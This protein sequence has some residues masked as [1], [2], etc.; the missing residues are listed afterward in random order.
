MNMKKVFLTSFLI[1]AVFAQLINVNAAD[2]EDIS[3]KIEL[4]GSFIPAV[5]V[6]D[7][8]GNETETTVNSRTWSIDIKQTDKKIYA[9]IANKLG[10]FVY[11]VT[12]IDE[13]IK[14]QHVPELAGQ[15]L[16]TVSGNKLY[17]AYADELLYCF[18]I[19]D[20][21]TVSIEKDN[22]GKITNPSYGGNIDMMI[23]I[24]NYVFA[25]RNYLEILVFDSSGENPA[26]A[27]NSIGERAKYKRQMAVKQVSGT[28]YRISYIQQSGSDFE[29]ICTDYNS[30]DNAS[31]EVVHEVIPEWTENRFGKMAFVTDSKIAV[32]NKL[33]NTREMLYTVDF[34]D[35][36]NNEIADEYKK[37]VCGVFG[38]S[39]NTAVYA[40][41]MQ[42][43]NE[44]ELA[45]WNKASFVK[46]FASG[47]QINLGSS[48]VLEAVTDAKDFAVFGDTASEFTD[49]LACDG[50]VIAVKI[51]RKIKQKQEVE[52]PVII[53]NSWRGLPGDAIGI[54]GYGFENEAHTARVVIVPENSADEE[55]YLDIL[56]SNNTCI[57]GVIPAGIPADN[58]I[59]HVECGD[60]K[61]DSF[62]INTPS[63]DWISEP[64]FCSGQ[65]VRIFGRNFLNAQTGDISKT[66][67]WLK[68]IS[69]GSE[70]EAE[71]V[72]ATDYT[73]DFKIPEC[74][75]EGELYTVKASN[76][77]ESSCNIYE[78]EESEA[79]VCKTNI[80]F[81][82]VKEKFG[83]SIGW[84]DELVTDRIFNVKNYGAAGNGITDD[85]AAAAAALKAAKDAGG[86]IIY[87][88]E[89]KYNLKSQ[90][91]QTIPD[92]SVICGAGKDKTTL[93][94]E[95]R[96]YS[97]DNYSG[98]YDLS[99]VSESVRPEDDTAKYIF[100]YVGALLYGNGANVHFFVSNIDMKVAD[101]SSFTSYDSKHLV[102]ENSSF[103]VTHC[104]PMQQCN[105]ITKIRKMRFVNNYVKNTQRPLLY[106]GGYSWI[107]GCIFEG[108]NGG[109]SCEKTNGI[110]QTMEH[111]IADLYGDKIFY[112]NNNI[113][114][115]VG[116][117]REEYDDS[118]GEG[119]CNQANK[120]IAVGS[121]TCST[122]NTLTTELD[123]ETIKT[124]KDSNG[125]VI[126][127]YLIGS[128]VAIISGN[129]VGQVRKI[130]AVE[131]NTITVDKPWTLLPQED[132]IYALNGEIAEKYIIVNNNIE[133]VTRKGGIMMYTS[134]FDNIIE[135][136]TMTN[137]G[138]IWF[139][140]TQS[141]G[142]ARAEISYFNYVANNN[143]S[144]GIPNKANGQR[145]NALYIGVGDDGGAVTNIDLDYPSISQYANMYKANVIEGNGAEVTA[146]S[147]YNSLFVDYNGIV[148]STPQE[149]FDYPVSKGV[150][151]SGN[152]ITNSV[153][154]I[155]V[156]NT[157][158]DTLIYN[159]AFTDNKY[160]YNNKSSD[161]SVVALSLGYSAEADGDVLL[162][163]AE[164]SPDGCLISADVQTA[165]DF[166]AIYQKY[167]MRNITDGNY[168]KMFA[169]DSR[170]LP[171][172]EAVLFE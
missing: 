82:T 116:D 53:N 110:V 150:I 13:A 51:A 65:T 57:E 168:I 95:K 160:N 59:C 148:L 83:V 7:E 137:S 15:G 10:L 4:L 151:V 128:K 70:A 63:V 89:G 44:N 141:A 167:T 55:Y 41:N 147:S 142:N 120:R 8:N 1:F 21:G 31:I 42:R 36:Y 3:Y 71:I 172:H 139:G 143:L 27:V 134:S 166:D 163:I 77:G 135:N 14:V 105:K 60:K 37:T 98:I 48:S 90:Q 5:T 124:Q 88:P 69:D 39:H 136:N 29:L 129:G 118:C 123:F 130:A 81:E 79:A 119:I 32:A 68:K 58:Y 164:Y 93:M 156:S 35:Y 159:N 50:M 46:T 140:K 127:T 133:A 161:N 54:Y 103:D 18:D 11:D 33:S 113:I 157:A 73:V 80:K 19:N 132:D 17:Y 117:K 149:G 107:D 12:N 45:L 145:D 75:T 40:S 76:N 64:E 171:L 112:G 78:L 24:D 2:S 99:I 165:A 169:F 25:Y 74:V 87:F 56:N 94:L 170:M 125:I 153:N 67:V 9:Y 144:G 6:T 61:S 138:G 85:T 23:S 52:R 111:R 106:F 121:V 30:S 91:E 97:S 109:D 154:G 49:Y 155:Y 62:T 16:L 131:G 26:V 92:L 158:S 100:G 126:G 115:I 96:I 146:E 38:Q 162:V 20:N 66:K 47:A 122:E 72:A 43:L 104:G 101:G 114:G 34:S 22:N 102:I 84:A 108:D 152:T 28:L 86:G